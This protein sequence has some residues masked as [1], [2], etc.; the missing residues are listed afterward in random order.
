VT[1]QRIVTTR[2]RCSL[3]YEFDNGAK[4]T[5]LS[6]AKVI[7]QTKLLVEAMGGLAEEIDGTKRLEI[8]LDAD[9]HFGF[10]EI[11]AYGTAAFSDGSTMRTW[12]PDGR[13]LVHGG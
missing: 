13:K 9:S 2:E 7:Q 3:S 4:R 8:M 5:G 11:G 12:S 1:K 6:G 10:D